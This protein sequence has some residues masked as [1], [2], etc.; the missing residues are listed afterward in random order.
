MTQTYRGKRGCWF[1]PAN[2]ATASE[3]WLSVTVQYVLNT[4]EK[5]KKKRRKVLENA[6]VYIQLLFTLLPIIINP[7]SF[8]FALWAYFTSRPAR[9]KENEERNN[10]R[11]R[12][13]RRNSLYSNAICTKWLT[14]PIIII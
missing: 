5:V 13:T 1:M 6:R 12:Y 2:S 10:S 8:Y 4:V 7:L 11:T 9:K 3:I 14:F